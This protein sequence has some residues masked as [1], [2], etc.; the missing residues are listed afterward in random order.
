MKISPDTVERLLNC[1]D[2]RSF[3]AAF[4]AS[5]PSSPISSYSNIARRAGFK[6]R[7]FPRDVVLGQKRITSSSL[8]PMIK[9]LGIQGALADYFKTLVNIEHPDTCFPEKTVLELRR[10]LENLRDRLHRKTPAIGRD[11]YQAEFFPLVYA[12]CGTKLKGVTLRDIEERTG[13]SSLQVSRTVEEL[14]GM[15]LL[16]VRKERYFPAGSHLAFDGLGRSEAFKK[17]F[18][19][20]LN[21]SA[22]K[23]RKNFD[24]SHQLFFTSCFSVQRDHLPQLKEE[25]RQCLLQFVDESENPNGNRVASIVCSLT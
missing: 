22:D 20:L 23:A 15:N 21:Q 16:Q 6:S 10:R 1:E 5:R 3:I 9:G 19:Y 17:L 14:I 12:A 18:F 4:K 25:L 8:Y 2:Y 11:P 7:S 24:S 13:L